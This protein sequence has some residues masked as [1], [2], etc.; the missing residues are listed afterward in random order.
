[1]GSI[2]VTSK[3]FELS[4]ELKEQVKQ[5]L[6]KFQPF[7]DHS[8]RTL[9]IFEERNLSFK[10]EIMFYFDGMF[11]K[12]EAKESSP[13][14]SLNRA[15]KKLEKKLNRI[16]QK[17]ARQYAKEL[18]SLLSSL[19]LTEEESPVTPMIT[20]RKSFFVKPMMEE[21]AILQ[22]ELLGHNSFMFFNAETET[23]CLLY[24]RKD[25]NYGIVEAI[26]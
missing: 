21:E 12:G 14:R 2:H 9:V 23:M 11:I 18:Q 22:M 15:I 17:Q 19:E 5:K 6:K 4:D 13:Q 1:M 20:K 8:H 26:Q 25:G 16:K 3:N 7:I 24:K 10:V